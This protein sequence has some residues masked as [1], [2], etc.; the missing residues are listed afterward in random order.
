MEERG[1]MTKKFVGILE[2]NIRVEKVTLPRK[3]QVLGTFDLTAAIF[4]V[5]VV[6]MRGYLWGCS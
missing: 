5:R 4:R 1:I 2:K 3:L 6:G